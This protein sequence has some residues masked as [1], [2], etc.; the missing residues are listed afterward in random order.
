LLL[1][2]IDLTKPTVE[3][4]E[5]LFDCLGNGSTGTFQLVTVPSP[6][7]GRKSIVPPELKP[8]DQ[9]LGKHPI[10][11]DDAGHGD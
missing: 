9:K 1:P 5:R 6:L 10:N 7:S 8:A 11:Q 4:I 3:S 2:F